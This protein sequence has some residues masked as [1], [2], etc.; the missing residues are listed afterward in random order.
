M[1]LHFFMGIVLAAKLT[2]LIPLQ[3]VRIVFFVLAGRV[4]ALLTDRAG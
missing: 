1:L 2:E 4:V 3:P